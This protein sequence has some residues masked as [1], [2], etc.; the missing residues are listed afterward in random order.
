MAEDRIFRIIFALL[1]L[2]MASIRVYYRYRARQQR[3]QVSYM[4]SRC[5]VVVQ[6][7]IGVAGLVANGAIIFA[8]RR[9][10]WAALP[11]PP[12]PRWFGAGLGVIALALL[13]WVQH[14]LG[15]N[16]STILHVRDGHTLV[17]SG[18]YRWVRHPMYTVIYLVIASWVV[19]SANW[20]VG[21]IWGGGI[22]AVLL[23]R[24]R[25][26]EAVMIETFGEQYGSYMRQ[27]GRFLPRLKQ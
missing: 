4:E 3:G 5:Q 17:T 21:L 15:R 20:F 14:T 22:T 23:V 19:V 11:F 16:F 12:G 8:P 7:L 2:T 9:M 26:E 24:L 1:F 27:T 6:T 18:P 10:A 25:R 13:V